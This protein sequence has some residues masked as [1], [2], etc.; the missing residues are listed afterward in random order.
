MSNF[1]D[2]VGCLATSS[3]VGAGRDAR[4]VHVLTNPVDDEDH[5]TNGRDPVLSGGWLLVPT[6]QLGTAKVSAPFAKLF[7]C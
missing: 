4:D 6:D 5:V 7:T 2:G 1:C 3:L